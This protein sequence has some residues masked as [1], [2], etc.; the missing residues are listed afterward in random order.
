MHFASLGSGSQGNGT[1]VRSDD[2]LLLVDCGFPRKETEIRMER[3]DVEPADLDAILVTHEHGD[4]CAGVASLSKAY[5][6]PV[7]L[8][9]GTAC[10]KKLD[11]CA[12]QIRFNAGDD[13]AIGGIAVTSV[14]VPHDAREPVQ[15]RFEAETDVLG[16]LTDLGSITPHVVQSFSGCHALLLEFNHDRDLLQQGPYPAVLKRRVGGDYGHLNN[17]QASRLLG[18]LDNQH[19]GVLVV[20]HLSQQNNSPDHARAA[21]EAVADSHQAAVV[22]ACQDSGFDWLS[23]SGALDAPA[24]SAAI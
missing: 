20:A 12:R 23:V 15:F 10:H 22:V 19:L 6:L 21:L 14:P 24:L 5:D 16:V 4:H 9:H 1:L 7:Y 18:Q 3:L 11:G 8:S 13:F 17:G 2:T